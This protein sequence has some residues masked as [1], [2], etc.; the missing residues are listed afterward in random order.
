[1]K[2]LFIGNLSTVLLP[3]C[4]GGSSNS[5]PSPSPSPSPSPG[6]GPAPEQ[7]VQTPSI[8][9]VTPNYDG[10]SCQAMVDGTQPDYQ[11]GGQ[12]V[13]TLSTATTSLRA[14]LGAQDEYVFHG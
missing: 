3:S 4:S 8:R 9:R 6:S 13:L 12:A 1:M 7:G 11:S 10:D 2:L 5:T 14:S